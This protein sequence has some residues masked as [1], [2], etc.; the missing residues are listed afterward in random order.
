LRFYLPSEASNLI[1]AGALLNGTSADPPGPVFP[2]FQGAFAFGT[3]PYVPAAGNFAFYVTD[4]SRVVLG[5]G[6]DSVNFLPGSGGGASSASA[7]SFTSSTNSFLDPFLFFLLK[8]EM[9]DDRRFP[10]GWY[11][12]PIWPNTGTLQYEHFHSKHKP[13]TLLQG[14]SADLFGN[15]TNG[16]T[17]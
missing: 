17:P 15:G 14:T 12:G 4:P 5:G 3:G 9:P 11:Q 10:L 16:G 8:F 7:S 13:G 6:G 2:N 1:T